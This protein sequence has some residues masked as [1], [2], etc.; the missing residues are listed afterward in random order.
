[1]VLVQGTPPAQP[2]APAQPPI[3]TQPSA[4]AQPP[5]PAPPPTPAQPPAPA[6]P[7]PPTAPPIP[8]SSGVQQPLHS[9][10]LRPRQPQDYR[11]LNSGIKQKCRKLQR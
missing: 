9:Q 8:G 3:Q 7:T 2:L 11:E 4:P 5:A 6:L 10:D 1:M